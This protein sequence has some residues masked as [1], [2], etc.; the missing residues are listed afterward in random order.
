MID[1]WAGGGEEGFGQ[2]HLGHILWAVQV[3]ARLT[4]QVAR[5]GVPSRRVEGVSAAVNAGSGFRVFI[6]WL[7]LRP[8]ADL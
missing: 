2:R 1:V 5:V 3:C 4:E 8:K 6:Q 7:L